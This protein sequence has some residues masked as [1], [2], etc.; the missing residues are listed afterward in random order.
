MGTK[1]LYLSIVFIDLL[2]VG[3]CQRASEQKSFAKD[4]EWGYQLI[5]D[6]HYSEAIDLFWRIIHQE[7]SDTARLGLASAY[8]ARAGIRIE[9]YWSLLKPNLQSTSPHQTVLSAEGVDEKYQKVLN[10]LPPAIQLAIQSKGPELQK[11]YETFLS[12]QRRFL[13]IPLLK[14]PE[15]AQDIYIAK[16]LLNPKASRGAALYRSLFS[17]VL[18]RYESESLFV[19]FKDLS[20]K[21][22]SKKE[23]ALCKG[24]LSQWV[25]RWE[26][27]IRLM[28]DFIADL[29]AA[30]STNVKDIESFE[31]EFNNA[32]AQILTSGQSVEGILCMNLKL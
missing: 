1:L 22:D 29:K 26:K 27:P 12:L 20:E 15:A 23:K 31:S 9:Q 14:S 3:A 30:S 28:D 32:K 16:K 2:F 4:V 21:N 11:S 13:Q 7:D 10:T 8:A 19:S 6:H 24:G 25:G 5:D 18:F 17:L